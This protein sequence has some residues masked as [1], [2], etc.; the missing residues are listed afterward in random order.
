M[1]ASCLRAQAF[2]DC[3]TTSDFA[4]LEIGRKLPVMTR[5]VLHRCSVWLPT[6]ENWVYNQVR[7]CNGEFE[8]HVACLATENLDRFPWP[9]LHP[10]PESSLLGKL[11]RTRL[12]GLRGRATELPWLWQ[13]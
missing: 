6:T 4:T 9:S 13:R 7:F 3:P 5:T 11:R 2:R 1:G 10:F 8:H 12:P